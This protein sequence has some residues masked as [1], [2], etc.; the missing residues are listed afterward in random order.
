MLE[1]EHQLLYSDQE[2]ANAAAR[3]LDPKQFRYTVRDSGS[4]VAWTLAVVHLEVPDRSALASARNRLDALAQ[5][6]G[7]RYAQ[8]ACRTE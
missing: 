2:A 5:R 1:V 3:A 8:Q 6:T 7:G 4:A